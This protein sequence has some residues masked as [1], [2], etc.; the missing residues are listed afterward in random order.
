[1]DLEML[2]L[3]IQITISNLFLCFRKY[4]KKLYLRAKYCPQNP[5]NRIVI[6]QRETIAQL[7]D[8]IRTLN[9]N[10]KDYPDRLIEFYNENKDLKNLI[11]DLNKIITDLNS[12]MGKFLLKNFV[13]NFYK[14]TLLLKKILKKK[15]F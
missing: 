13:S 14:L 2:I 4:I 1:M 6:Q 9:K 15:V 10:V 8:Q 7:N 5:I 3:I 11:E 12:R